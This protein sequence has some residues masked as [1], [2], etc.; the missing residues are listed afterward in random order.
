MD[1]QSLFPHP[2]QRIHHFA[3]VHPGQASDVWLV[4]TANEQAIVRTTRMS[5]QPTSDFWFGCR[6]LFGID[7]TDVF[8]M[9]VVNQSLRPVSLISI[10]RVVRKATV[11]GVPFVVVE[12]ISGEPVQSFLHLP[13]EAIYELGKG[14]AS[15]HQ[16]Q[17]TTCGN[18]RGTLAYPVNQFHEHV[19]Q[20]IP[21]LVTRFHSNDAAILSEMPWFVTE[22]ERNGASPFAV[23]VLLDMDP[24]Q[25][26]TNGSRITG[27]IDTEVYA[28]GPP[29]L[30]L[31][32][33]EYLLDEPRAQAFQTGYRQL[34]DFPD[35]TRVRPLYRY[36]HLLLSVQGE[37]PLGQWMNHP[38]L[39]R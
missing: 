3:D 19:A 7:P 9:E 25:F 20:L 22:F 21:Q 33:L 35:L 39:F 10:P 28:F 32:A 36:L 14:I 6:H 18:F 37:V 1:L 17:R 31:V 24:T 29:E 27:L 26:L 12:V 11:H 8:A 15:I 13:A 34:R 23:P 30:D 4:T 2:I 5:S 38:I 16:L